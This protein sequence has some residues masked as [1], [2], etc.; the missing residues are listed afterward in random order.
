LEL[1]GMALERSVVTDRSNQIS[2]KTVN[3]STSWT[4]KTQRV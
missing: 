2:W 3:Y 4:R 1:E